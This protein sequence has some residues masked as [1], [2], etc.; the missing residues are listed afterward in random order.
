[1]NPRKRLIVASMLALGA[2]VN[3]LPVSA[4][5]FIVRVPVRIDYMPET[6]APSDAS[7]ICRA[8]SDTLNI[9]SGSTR[10]EVTDDQ[11][12]LAA[13]EGRD[14][15]NGI[16]EVEL[17][18]LDEYDPDLATA[19]TCNLSFGAEFLDYETCAASG[20]APEDNK[21]RCA[22]R[23]AIWHDAVSGPIAESLPN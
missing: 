6:K 5:D 16:I 7:V 13:L 1:M 17:H 4:Q 15:W 20:I 12:M 19:V 18:A 22:E 10:L 11:E 2:C 9:A 21:D 23:D 14:L 8:H 3:S